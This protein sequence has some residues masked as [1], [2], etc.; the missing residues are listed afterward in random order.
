MRGHYGIEK[1][2]NLDE[3]KLHLKADI[4]ML[5][6]AIREQRKVLIFSSLQFILLYNINWEKWLNNSIR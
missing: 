4:L 6:I 3:F 5:F 1:F 2:F